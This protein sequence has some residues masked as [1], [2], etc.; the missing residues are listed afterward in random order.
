MYISNRI[1]N[2]RH[3]RDTARL[4]NHFIHETNKYSYILEV[5]KDMQGQFNRGSVWM[6]G[7]LLMSVFFFMLPCSFQMFYNFHAKSTF[8]TDAKNRMSVFLDREAGITDH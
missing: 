6:V 7:F 3:P 8:I 4:R 5:L 2:E 1:G